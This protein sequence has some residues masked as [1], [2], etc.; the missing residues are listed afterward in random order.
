ML[1]GNK[2]YGKKEKVDASM[3]NRASRAGRGDKDRSTQEMV[4]E[5]VGESATQGRMFQADSSCE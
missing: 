2:C 5:E 1:E 3:S 4:G